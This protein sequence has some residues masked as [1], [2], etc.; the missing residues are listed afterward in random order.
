[1]NATDK[2]AVLDTICKGMREMITADLLTGVVIEVITEARSGS[3]KVPL[4]TKL[5]HT[6]TVGDF[7][8]LGA[9]WK[10]VVIISDMV[11]CAAGRFVRYGLNELGIDASKLSPVML[12]V[13]ISST[14]E[15]EAAAVIAV[16]K[17]F[18]EAF[19]NELM[20]EKLASEM[21]ARIVEF[22]HPSPT[23]H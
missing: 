5:S 21:E 3:G 23:L 7:V 20:D 9:G 11:A 6:F 10:S 12:M 14:D 18:N 16:R 4:D 15:A 2:D 19:P 22:N 8:R 13:I 1:M 17:H